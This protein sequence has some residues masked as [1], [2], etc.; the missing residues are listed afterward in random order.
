MREIVV[1]M[2]KTGG[3]QVA[4]LLCGA[5]S[6]KLMA[7]TIGPSGVG[8]FSIVRQFQQM[9]TAVVSVGGQNALVQGIASRQSDQRDHFL[10]SVSIIIVGASLVTAVAII[11]CAP[12]LTPIIFGSNADIPAALVRWTGIGGAIGAVLVLFR[13]LL[14]AQMEIGAVAWANVAAAAGSV[15]L[16]LPAVTAYKA[17]HSVSLALLLVGSLGCGAAVAIYLAWKRRY[18]HPLRPSPAFTFDFAASRE[19]LKVALPSLGVMFAGLGSVL[20]VKATIAR[21]HGIASAG[22]FDVAWGLSNVYLTLLLG[23]L[24]SYL[25]PTLSVEALNDQKSEVLDKALRLSIIIAVPLITTVIVVKPLVVRVLY[26]GEFV[27]ALDVLRW[28]LLGDYLRVTGW[29]LATVLF[30]RVDIRAYVACEALW[31][32][33]LVAVAIGWLHVH[34][35][36]AGVAYMVASGVYLAILGYR[37]RSR[38]GVTFRGSQIR[39]WAIGAGIVLL[40]SLFTWMHVGIAWQDLSF[41]PI[42]LLFSWMALT[43][44]ERSYVS[45][46]WKRWPCN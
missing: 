18:L 38:H 2:L 45:G 31:S 13:S 21:G 28:T 46:Y 30:A 35:S 23:S 44:S 10:Q 3:G 11:A 40:A 16:V 33:T 41:I 37:V 14:N 5:I 7:V 34:L 12:L 1:A 17:G 29:V 39:L 20:I 15:V 4:T 27:G 22:Q 9:L 36:M 6:V 32:A 26:S 24:H 19:F 42:A 25:L 8:I 43:Q